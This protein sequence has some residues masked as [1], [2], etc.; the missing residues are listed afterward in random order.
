MG[1]IGK[2]ILFSEYFGIDS[3]EMSEIGIFNPILNLD[4]RLF[5]DPILLKTSI[6]EIINTDAAQEYRTYFSNIISLLALS[7]QPDDFAWKN[8]LKQLPEKEI[9]GTCLGYGT[10]SISGRRM[11]ED[12]KFSLITTAKGIIDLGIKDP[13]L[14]SILPLFNK[15]IGPDTISDI[16]TRA[17]HKSLLKFSAAHAK[18]LKIPTERVDLY[19]EEWDV[20][21]NPIRRKSHILL[22]PNDILRNLPIVNDWNDIAD[23][24]SFNS[25]L[26]HKINRLVAE[27]FKQK[28]KESRANYI[29]E[30]MHDKSAILDFIEVIR[31]C[32]GDAYNQLVDN[33]RIV[34]FSKAAEIIQQQPCDKRSFRKNK[35]GLE[36]LVATIIDRFQFLVED[37]G[38]NKLLWKEDKKN[39]CKESVA[40]LIFHAVALIYCQANDIDVS[41]E[42][43]TGTGLIDFKFSDGYRNKIIV[44]IKYSDNPSLLHGLEKQLQQ[45]LKSEECDKG[46]YVV[47]DVGKLD[48]KLDKMNKLNND[49]Q[50][51]S[52]IF[53]IDAQLKKSASKK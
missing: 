36:E 4:T 33:D 47:L 26:R 53:Y 11:N 21:T 5:I 9:D 46:Y 22:L 8:A 31:G 41:P 51:K 24:A 10:N 35:S 16:A 14:F 40:Q 38:L 29:S 34:V 30:I 25:N 1:K 17:I 2:L 3:K 6:H 20:I 7:K 18:I 50:I 48:S 44:E 49:A 43:D 12:I 19:G 39:R 13:E 15:G 37:K 32:K 23:A 52:E 28:T 27:I 45:Y 42:T